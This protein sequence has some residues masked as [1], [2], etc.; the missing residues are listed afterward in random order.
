V[1]DRKRPVATAT[2]SECEIQSKVS[3]ITR[4]PAWHMIRGRLYCAKCAKTQPK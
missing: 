1:A 3:W 4:E 2:C